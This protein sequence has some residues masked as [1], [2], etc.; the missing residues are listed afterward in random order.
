MY[1]AILFDLDG[2]LTDPKEG[3]T[4]CVQYALSEMGINEPNLDKLISFIGPPLIDSFKELYN[5]S[6]KDALSAVSFYRRRFSKIGIYENSVINGIPE[7]L[8]K[9]KK[10]GKTIALATSKPIIYAERILEYYKLTNYFDIITGAELD[11]TRSE[12]KDVIAEVLRQLPGNSLPVMVGDRRQD[13]FGAKCCSV[14]CIGVRF[15]Y[16]EENELEDAGADMIAENVDELYSML[17]A[18]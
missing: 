18:D 13:V 12:K 7:M 8:A 11:G 10:K 9:L 4:K 15:G 5:M 3:I 16:A 2:T 6:E 1:T 14:P 17:I